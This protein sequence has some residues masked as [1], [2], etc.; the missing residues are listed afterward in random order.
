MRGYGNKAGAFV[1]LSAISNTHAHIPTP[2]DPDPTPDATLSQPQNRACE[3][4]ALT[5][6]LKAVVWEEPTEE[7]QALEL[8][9]R[10]APIDMED[11]LELLSPAFTNQAVRAYAVSRLSSVDDDVRGLPALMSPKPVLGLTCAHAH[12]RR[13]CPTGYPGIATVLAAAGAGAQV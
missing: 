5:K 9:E 10:W 7:R 2:P 3:F 8:L 1:L 6:F 11:A 12:A 13:F 4:Q